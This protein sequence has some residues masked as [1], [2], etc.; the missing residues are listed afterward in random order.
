MAP[1]I[2][3]YAAATALLLAT[4]ITAAPRGAEGSVEARPAPAG[5]VALVEGGRT[6]ATVRLATPPGARGTAKARVVTVAGRRIVELRVP[7]QGTGRTEAWVAEIGMRDATPIWSG[8]VG[9]RGADGEEGL[10]LALDENGIVL[11]ETAVRA[12]RCDGKP[13]RLF[14]RAWDFVARTFRATSESLPAPATA[15]IRATRAGSGMPAGAPL[16]L[17]QFTVASSGAGVADARGLVAP[18]ALDDA[19]H[20][21]SW[22]AVGGRGDWATARAA[23]PEAVVGLRILPGDLRDRDR[24]RAT[25]RPTRL[26]LAFGPAA[27]ER[28]DVE[29]VEDE[30]GGA[31]RWRVPFWVPLPRPVPSACLTLFV[32]DAAPAGAPALAAVEIFTAADGPDGAARAVAALAGDDRCEGRVG[33]VSALGHRAIS[34]LLETIPGAPLSNRGCLLDALASVLPEPLPPDMAG[35]ISEA[36]VRILAV[37]AEGDLAAVGKVLRRLPEPPIAALASSLRDGRLPDGVRT[38]AARLLAEIDADEARRALVGGVGAE[39]PA[40]RRGL[41]PLVAGAKGALGPLLLARLLELPPGDDAAR[42]ELLLALGARISAEP[43]L[44]GEVRAAL[45][46][47]LGTERGFVVRARAIEALGRFGDDEAA[48]RLGRLRALEPDPVLRFLAVQQLGENPSPS[49]IEPLRAAAA[50]ADPRV[51]ETAATALGRRVDRGA[52]AALVAGA[53]REPWPAVRRAQIAA[54]GRLCVPEGNDLLLRANE[55][56]VPEV[57][58][59]ALVG[60]ARCRDPRA[61]GTLLAVLGREVEVAS[62]RALAATLLGDLGD[63]SAT[64]AV[65]EALRRVTVE[66]QVDL[67]LEPVAVAATRTLGALGGAEAMGGAL[68]LLSDPRPS[69]RRAA[70]DALGQICDAGAGAR[71]VERALADPDAAVAAAASSAQ[72]R[73]RARL[74]RTGALP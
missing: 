53:K 54:L 16:P 67:S 56:D 51:R 11:H 40:V 73:C 4:A 43:G 22:T 48:R 34:P 8:L 2:A 5:A 59:A 65:A 33:A 3:S 36:L 12:L 6:I 45:E 55:R 29:L 58:R 18:A 23:R 42:G 49:A 25:G 69:L 20:E 1:V 28:F 9:P 57:R 35:R 37:P 66:S 63:P 26:A 71:A 19:R 32:R 38:R 61:P 27:E 31:R 39:P 41:R 62:L 30:D 72:R 44:R 24:F 14:P 15:V 68:A 50:D 7:V 70:L 74:P 47:E 21:T 52:A 13:A 17:F 10:A 60:L 64:R 46:R